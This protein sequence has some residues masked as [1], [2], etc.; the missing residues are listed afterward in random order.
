MKGCDK[1]PAPDVRPELG[2]AS[3]MKAGS[4]CPP[5]MADSSGSCRS[6]LAQPVAVLEPHLQPWGSALRRIPPRG[7]D[8][9]CTPRSG[10]GQQWGSRP[11]LSV[12]ILAPCSRMVLSRRCVHRV[13]NSSA[14]APPRLPCHLPCPR[15]AGKGPWSGSPGLCPSPLAASMLQALWLGLEQ[16][17]LPCTVLRGY[18]LLP[19]PLAVPKS[20]CSLMSPGSAR[21]PLGAHS[22]VLCSVR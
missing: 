18:G 14:A 9:C 1:A 6:R 12:H 15:H 22:E 21:S 3:K 5:G 16:H 20:W 7:E 8:Q 19:G 17:F 2:P 10:T 11:P 4:R 13:G